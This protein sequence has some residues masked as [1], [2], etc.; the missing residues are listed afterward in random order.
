VTLAQRPAF[1][2][3]ALVLLPG[4]FATAACAARVSPEVAALAAPSPVLGSGAVPTQ[5]G[6]F[7][8]SKVEAIKFL[9]ADTLYRFTDGSVAN[10]SAVR[11]AIAPDVKAGSDSQAWTAREGEKFERIQQILLRQGRIESYRTYLSQAQRLNLGDAELIEHATVLT[12]QK[13]DAGT[14]EF[15]YVYLI[16]GRFLKVRGT[17]PGDQWQA[18]DFPAFARE[19]ARQVRIASR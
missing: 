10:V 3:R 18:S 15:A 4:L 16:G 14:V 12:V 8:L 9:P 19:L 5:V 2:S 1:R 7:R 11:Y 17:F 6:R 13:V